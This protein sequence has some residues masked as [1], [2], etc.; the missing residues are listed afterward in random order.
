M[1]S[2]P[3]TNQ[4]LYKA[5][6]KFDAK[7]ELNEFKLGFDS[8]KKPEEGEPKSPQNQLSGSEKLGQS[9]KSSP[10]Y[11]ADF[12]QQQDGMEPEDME[13]QQPEQE[14]SQPENQSPSKIQY[15][16]IV[17]NLYDE[18]FNKKVGQNS[19]KIQNADFINQA[20]QD[21][22]MQI[23]TGEHAISFF[24]KYGN[25]TPIKFITCVRDDS[26]PAEVFR[27]YDLKVIHKSENQKE[28]TLNEYYTI[29]AHGIVHVWTE[30][31]KK[32]LFEQK[33]T[34]KTLS[35]TDTEVISLS[36]WM[37]ES[38]MFNIITNIQFFK[39]YAIS[40]IFSIWKKNVHYRI[41]CKTRR[42][43]IE[44]SFI[45][46]PAFSNHLLEINKMIYDIRNIKSI[47]SSISQNKQYELD[48]FKTDQRK[49]R[50]E[51][52][53]G[54]E[55]I[56]EKIIVEVETTCKEVV[57]RTKL[58]DQPEIEEARFGQQVKQ[59]PMNEIRKEAE[60]KA[61]LLKRAISDKEKLRN[62]IRATDYV[63]VQTLYSTYFISLQMLV[64]EMNRKDRK[65]GMFNTTV[66]FDN[67]QMMYTPD[68]KDVTETLLN[69]LDDMIITV[70]STVRVML[71]M[72]NYV[73]MMNLDNIMDLSKIIVDSDRFKAL[74][75]EIIAK[76]QNDFQL[77][78]NYVNKNYEICR[79]IHQSELQGQQYDLLTKEKKMSEIK[80]DINQLKKWE[81]NLNNYIKDAPQGVLQVDGKKIKIRLLPY[82]QKS[83]DKIQEQLLILMRMRIETLKKQL[84]SYNQ[85]LSKLPTNLKEYAE[86]I[87]YYNEVVEA[88]ADKK[89]DNKKLEIE[90]M[91]F[92][93][94]QRFRSNPL[95]QEDLQQK[96]D[97]ME[98]T[99]ICTNLV[100]L[101]T[102]RANAEREI[103]ENKSDMVT[104]LEGEMENLKKFI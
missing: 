63:V 99:D 27:P 41:Y 33:D 2:V 67:S 26:H 5:L 92:E 86:Y 91:Q 77:A 102:N 50:S 83:Q 4:E 45:C 52:T 80:A 81:D 19:N 76:I 62:F 98:Y 31:G 89:L 43:L 101:T 72:D 23:R 90:E 44:D 87:E 36:D 59:K 12:V 3:E 35:D 94:K 28:L 53:T 58:K 22:L 16:Q 34:L 8:G 29:S 71:R 78:Q 38:T 69:L 54:Y 70:K 100:D 46:K 40:K 103:K 21:I 51:A 13:Q 11:D 25:T 65:T 48:D 17:K 96:K 39:N 20:V 84:V 15:T 88:M 75:E 74:R 57:D 79:P 73:K 30:K 61:Y 85:N 82:V 60:E 37:H 49:S 56:V 18:N 66:M 14:Q 7:N 68:E 47:S 24:A 93:L 6:Y 97:N 9:K 10:K 64:D 104:K 1:L 55:N 42:K 32:I 95:K